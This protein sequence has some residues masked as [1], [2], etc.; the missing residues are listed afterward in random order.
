[1]ELAISTRGASLWVR[2]DGDRLARL[3]QQRL[4]G[5][6]RPSANCNDASKSSQVRAARPMPP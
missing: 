5:L 2:N 4:V 3:H 1:L 6:E